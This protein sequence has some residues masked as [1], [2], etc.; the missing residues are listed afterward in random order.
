MRLWLIS[1]LA[2]ALAA[3]TRVNLHPPGRESWLAVQT[4]DLGAMDLEPYQAMVTV[5]LPR[6]VVEGSMAVA[7]YIGFRIPRPGVEIRPAARQMV[8]TLPG[9]DRYWPGEDY[10]RVVYLS[11][12]PP[13]ADALPA[14][15]P[16]PPPDEAP[17]PI[18]RDVMRKG[19]AQ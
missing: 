8:L 6:A 9:Y 16:P 1:M 11:T 3:Q 12:E 19:G 17:V 5:T 15:P 4:I 7:F 14:P 18:P 2:L 10:I 13:P